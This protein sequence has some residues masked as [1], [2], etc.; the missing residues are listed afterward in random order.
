MGKDAVLWKVSFAFL[1]KFTHRHFPLGATVSGIFLL[2]PV[3]A[4]L[5]LVHMKAGDFCALTLRLAC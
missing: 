1:P 4:S 3:S 5:L 2:D